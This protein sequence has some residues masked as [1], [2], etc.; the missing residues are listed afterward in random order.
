MWKRRVIT[1]WTLLNVQH[2]EWSETLKTFLNKLGENENV[3]V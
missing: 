2:K 3:N 1:T